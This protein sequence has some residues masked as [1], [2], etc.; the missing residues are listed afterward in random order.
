M[1]KLALSSMLHT[2]HYPN[3]MAIAEQLS[4][5]NGGVFQQWMVYAGSCVK[6]GQQYFAQKMT[7]AAFKAA[8]LFSPQRV[9]EMAPIA[10]TVFVLQ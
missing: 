4:A 7:G 2:S 9:V 5:Y 3:V 6:G 1:T 8:K 10:L